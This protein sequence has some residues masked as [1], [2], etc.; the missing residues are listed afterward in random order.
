MA[1]V[2]G[3]K[4]IL[5]AR[6]GLA[7]GAR[8][9]RQARPEWRAI[10][11]A[12][13]VLIRESDCA[14][15]AS[16][17]DEF[18]LFEERCKPKWFLQKNGIGPEFGFGKSFRLHSGQEPVYGLPDCDHLGKVSCPIVHDK[19]AEGPEK[20]GIG[21]VRTSA[22]HQPYQSCGD[23]HVGKPDD[24]IGDDIRPEQTLFANV[25][26]QMGEKIRREKCAR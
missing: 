15:S 10:S 25:A 19:E 26:V 18:K 6:A 14:G 9:S 20:I 17:P 16:A 2:S 4:G 7:R 11:D 24:E 13:I 21:K 22:T 3:G 12:F 1:G 8:R 5:E 23:G